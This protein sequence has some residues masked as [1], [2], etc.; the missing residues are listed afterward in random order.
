M[1]K[2]KESLLTSFFIFLMLSAQRF[3]HVIPNLPRGDNTGLVVGFAAS[4]VFILV[5]NV[6]FSGLVSTGKRKNKE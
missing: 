1:K 6:I 5:L 2:I 3:F 4:F